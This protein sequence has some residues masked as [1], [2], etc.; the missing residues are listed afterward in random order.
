[1]PLKQK[2]ILDDMKK[3]ITNLYFK[4]N[5]QKLERI[6][7]NIRKNTK[8]TL[9]TG[10]L[11]APFIIALGITTAG[12]SLGGATPFLTD[13]EKSN[14][15]TMKEL[16]SLGN[17]R[18]E[19][20][21]EAFDNTQN[22]ISFYDTWYQNTDGSYS[23]KIKIYDFSDISEDGI[24]D[25][26]NNNIKSLDDIFGNPIVSKVETKDKLSDEELS[27]K[28][29][30]K[31]RMYLEDEEDFIYVEQTMNKNILET[32]IYLLVTILIELIIINVSISSD[33]YRNYKEDIENIKKK[34]KIEDIDELL[35][36][37]EIRESNYNRLT[38]FNGNT[39]LE[40]SNNACKLKEEIFKYIN[41]NNNNLFSKISSSELLALIILLDEFNLQLRS[42]LNTDLS[43]TFGFEIELEQADRIEISEELDE[44]FHK[45]WELHDDSTLKN[46]LEIVSPILNNRTSYWNDLD[47]V[48]EKLEKFAIVGKNSG[49]H[50]HI[51]TQILGDDRKAWLNFIKLWAVYENVIF[52][53][54]YGEYLTNRPKISRYAKPI[55]ERLWNDYVMLKN[56]N[57]NFSEIIKKISYG[58]YYAINFEHIDNGL[59]KEGNTIEFRSP[60]SSLKSVIWQNNTNLFLS[61]LEYAKADNFNDE[62]IDLRHSFNL[63]KYSDIKWYNEIYLEQALELCDLI[64]NN[65][66]DK[67]YFLKQYLKSFEVSEEEFGK[68]KSLVK[69][70]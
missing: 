45:K 65:N 41:R 7:M 11:I 14:L 31:I 36:K 39:L 1:M 46:G 22:T 43:N 10:R 8:I 17:I 28:P 3:D 49:G 55:G 56:S 47:D 44:Y 20:Q 63:D 5:H 52:R 66:C 70:K 25:I 26:L 19:Q 60:N 23:R 42:R 59:Y 34:Y 64:F 53:F 27:S 16:D 32:L 2:K 18:Y 37:I 40:K 69:E 9:R 68:T 58:K 21:Y 15:K 57:A 54:T 61:M 13:K 51:G 29:S 50:I 24:D 48:C 30:L 33:S 38:N 12:F 67:I 62:I 4:V 35:K 6:K